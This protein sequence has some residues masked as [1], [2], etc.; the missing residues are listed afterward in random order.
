MKKSLILTSIVCLCLI[1][2]FDSCK[3]ND[4][5]TNTD[6]CAGVTV[7][8]SLSKTDPTN[9]SDNGV[10][11]ATA[12]NGTGFTYSIN[13]DPFQSSN[14]FTG[15][16]VGTYTITAKSS[17]GCIGTASITLN[18]S[19]TPDSCTNPNISLN[20]SIT[21]MIPCPGNNG[22][23]TV[24]ATGANIVGYS[25]DGGVSYQTGN[26]FTS[27]ANG[28]YNIKVKDNAGCVAKGTATVGTKPRGTYFEKVKAIINSKCGGGGNC[29]LNGASNKGHN[30][31]NECS[32]ITGWSMLNKVI[33]K[34]AGVTAMPLTGSP[35]LT[36]QE[37]ND[38]N[39][40]ISAG[41]KYTD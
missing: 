34:Q 20:F 17:D 36:S 29:H 6:P 3:K 39:T 5:N 14:T 31:D 8:V 30:Y 28:S 12:T 7:Q 21:D 25:K 13:N 32:I 27:L 38:F 33:N 4:S 1:F 41:H 19:S 18:A 23:I 2:V 26:V 35:Q 15:L 11:V 9:G 24:S 16:F 10:I 22:S 40:W 37:L